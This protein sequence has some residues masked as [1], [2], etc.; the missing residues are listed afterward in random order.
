MRLLLV[1]G[2]EGG[3]TW[4]FNKVL[5]PLL[6][7]FYGTD[8]VVKEAS[9]NKASRL[10][11]GRGKTIH[12]ANKLTATSSLRTVNT[13]F[14]CNPVTVLAF[15]RTRLSFLNC[16]LVGR[17]PSDDSV[18]ARATLLKRLTATRF[19]LMQLQHQWLCLI[20]MTLSKVQLM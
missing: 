14:Q 11:Q 4:I 10:L 17:K 9:S 15:I 19:L 6:T 7:A 1:G 3:K 5:I 20:L 18:M 16:R 8:G 13:H 2:G 12:A